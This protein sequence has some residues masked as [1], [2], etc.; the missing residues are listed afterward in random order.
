MTPFSGLRR[1]LIA[2][3]ATA[4]ALAGIA[5]PAHPASAAPSGTTGLYGSGDPTYDGVFRQSLAIMGLTA[6]GNRPAVAAVTWLIAQQCQDGSFQAYRVDLTKPCDPVDAANYAGPDTNSTATA[7]MALMALDD[8]N[9][10][11]GTLLGKVVDAASKATAWLRRQQN[12][13]GGWPWTTGGPSDANSTGLSLAALLTQAPTYDFPAYRKASRYL[14]R[15]SASCSAGGGFAFQ[16]GGPANASATAQGLTGLVGP[17]PV[18][19]PRKIAVAAPCASNAKAKGASYLARTLAATGTLTSPYGSD[20][21]F[22]STAF[23]VLGLAADGQGRAAVARATAALKSAATS[24][25]SR[26]GS[27]DPA[28]L[29]L[30]LMVAEA[31]GSKPTSFGGVNLVSSLTGSLR[32]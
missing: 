11:G 31:T 29:G 17:M 25:T 19:G 5:L 27:P 18:N 32:K 7:A 26:A 30:L 10:V 22:S 12:A 16:S 15:Q 4:V 6:T 14:G 13:D 23:A 20:P 8:R 24:Y 1:A 28:A 21:D 9:A 3:A 2:T